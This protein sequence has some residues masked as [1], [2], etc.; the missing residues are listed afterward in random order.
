MRLSKVA[1]FSDYLAY[2]IVV[3][4][5]AGA[6]LRRPTWRIAAHWGLALVTGIAAWTLLEYVLHRIAL[7]RIA[8]F[9]RLHEVHHREPQALVG[10]PTWLSLALLFAGVWVPAWLLAGFPIAS[11][12]T[13]GVMLG[14]LWY[15]V[16]HHLIHHRR[17]RAAPA[18]FRRLRHSHMRHH[19]ATATGNFGVTTAL[20]DRLLGTTIRSSRAGTR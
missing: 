11:G 17:S 10:T 2:P 14:Y 7:H 15:G 19:H 8:V 13:V 20:W 1:Y 3:V 4:A 12:L 5:L 16:L 6:A 9:A 18:I